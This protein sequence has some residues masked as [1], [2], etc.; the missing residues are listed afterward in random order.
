MPCAG[1][2]IEPS[3][4]SI[5]AASPLF[6]PPV[7]CRSLR[8]WRCAGRQMML[9]AAL[10]IF[11]IHREQER[12]IDIF[13]CGRRNT[14]A[15]SRASKCPFCSGRAFDDCRQQGRVFRLQLKAFSISTTHCRAAAQDYCLPFA[16]R[17]KF[18]QQLRDA[19]GI[20]PRR[21]RTMTF[22]CTPITMLVQLPLFS[23]T[24]DY[25]TPMRDAGA[26]I[27]RLQPRFAL[28]LVLLSVGFCQ[29]S[30]PGRHLKHFARR[31]D[32]DAW[33]YAIS[34][35][36]GAHAQADYLYAERPR[37]IGATNAARPFFY[38]LLAYWRRRPTLTIWRRLTLMMPRTPLTWPLPC[39]HFTHSMRFSLRRRK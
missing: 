10:M 24:E 29:R 38:S 6:T 27:P 37:F 2:F 23:T 28:R 39:C 15:R 14:P 32:K 16:E 9:L 22:R 12:H 36:R 7:D 30:R 34:Y 13:R 25:D 35:M 17:M 18:T 31:C 11:I 8:W 3:L 4:F 21:C 1:W 19:R 33:W 5:Y 20:R 26:L